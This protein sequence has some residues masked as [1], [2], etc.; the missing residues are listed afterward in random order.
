[1]KA[2]IIAA[3]LIVGGI[4]IGFQAFDAGVN[5]VAKT[6]TAQAIKARQVL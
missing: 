1:M 3:L 5:S 6:E 2:L 4:H